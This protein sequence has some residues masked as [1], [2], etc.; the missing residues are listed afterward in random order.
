M[1]INA[2]L[3]LDE[4]L[5]SEGGI[6]INMKMYLYLMR[7]LREYNEW[8]QT[9]LL[10]ILYRYNP[11]QEREKER[12]EI[13][14]I[15][16]EKLKHSSTPLVLGSIKI[17]LKLTEKKE[18]LYRTIVEKIK[19]P[20][21]TLM[22]GNENSGSYETMYVVLQHIEYVILHMNGK[23]YFEKD[24][25]YFYC[26]A[27]EPTY[28]K[29]IKVKIL[30]ELANEYNLGDLLNELN[31]Y[32]NDVDIEMARKSVKILTDIALRLPEVSKALL[33]NL[34]S[35]F[36][37]DKAYLANEAML[38]FHQILRKFP[39]LFPDVSKSITEYRHTI[40]ETESTKS[41]IWLLGT[42]SQ[43]IDEAPYILE[44]YIA[45]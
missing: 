18:E 40:N 30:G 5:V 24:F 3:A 37:T 15:L 23:Q 1:S 34:D 39:K 22:S 14:G 36:R 9:C 12:Y 13:M 44:E 42:F 8:Q 7:R 21:I 45:D 27:D 19:A 35:Y 20:L 41:L 31:D 11:E 43:S 17:I 32:A 28:I 6:P 25:K 4:I 29:S 33:I 16:W 26:K 38:S 10:D 2:F